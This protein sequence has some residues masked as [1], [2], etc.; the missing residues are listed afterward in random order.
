MLVQPWED[1]VSWLRESEEYFHR[2]E[3]YAVAAACRALLRRA[4]ASVQQRRAGVERVPDPLRAAGVTVREYEV[5]E[6]LTRRLSNKAIA[7]RLTGSP[8]TAP[9]LDEF[10]LSRFVEGQAIKP[11]YPYISGIQT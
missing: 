11:L 2:A 6:L 7:E 3:V 5:L 4:G 1:P 8:T 10:R 9:E